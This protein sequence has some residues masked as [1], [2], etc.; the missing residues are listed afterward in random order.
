[1]SS[2]SHGQRVG[3]NESGGPSVRPACVSAPEPRGPGVFFAGLCAVCGRAT[4]Q[5]D[6]A[7]LPRHEVAR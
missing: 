1:V 2:G 3:F 6:A 4:T 5:R 7:G